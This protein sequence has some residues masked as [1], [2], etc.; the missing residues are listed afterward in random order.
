MV[1]WKE[2]RH[3]ENT[4]LKTFYRIK[5]TDVGGGIKDKFNMKHTFLSSAGAV[6]IFAFIFSFVPEAADMREGGG[7]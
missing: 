2:R 5:G 3:R 1:R 4:T 7:G 6:L